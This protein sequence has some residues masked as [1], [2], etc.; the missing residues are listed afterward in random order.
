VPK[1]SPISEVP[2]ALFSLRETAS[3]LK[4][5]MTTLQRAISHGLVKF[6]MMG[7]VVRIPA[8]EVERIARDGLGPIPAGY[9]RRTT[10]R[11]PG[12]PYEKKK[13]R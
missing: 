10:G 5:G 13:K 4:M 1:A 8:A 12:R 7:R 3:T 6:N 11:A 9:K 2:R